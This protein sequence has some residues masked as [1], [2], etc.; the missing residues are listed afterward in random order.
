MANLLKTKDAMNLICPKS[1]FGDIH[2]KVKFFIWIGRL[3]SVTLDPFFCKQS[4]CVDM[5]GRG[6]TKLPTSVALPSGASMPLACRR[7]ESKYW[8]CRAIIIT[9]K[10]TFN[11]FKCPEVLEP[12]FVFSVSSILIKIYNDLKWWISLS[13]PPWCIE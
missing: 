5:L 7:N 2:V 11:I 13:W 6:S 10:F 4:R 8:F 1:V 3:L 12:T 9:E